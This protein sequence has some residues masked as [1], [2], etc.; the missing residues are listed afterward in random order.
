MVVACEARTRRPPPCPG[1]SERWGQPLGFRSGLM[2]L[3]CSVT[4][5][6]CT[7]SGT[8]S[9]IPTGF[10]ME[11]GRLI[12]RGIGSA[13]APEKDK[14]FGDARTHVAVLPAHL[15]STP[16]PSQPPFTGRERGPQTW[17]PREA[18]APALVSAVALGFGCVLAARKVEQDQFSYVVMV[19]QGKVI[20][21]EVSPDRRW[22]MRPW[23]RSMSRGRPPAGDGATFILTSCTGFRLPTSSGRWKGPH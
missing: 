12:L 15:P 1:G 7:D 2:P 9:R 20:S 13:R 10:W 8:F 21:C 5:K 4:S 23:I 22:R 14:L 18:P 17:H 11:T 19:T 3:R 6:R 16:G